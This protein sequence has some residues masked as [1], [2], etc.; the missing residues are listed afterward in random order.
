MEGGRKGLRNGA[1][2]KR[3]RSENPPKKQESKEKGKN[4]LSKEKGKMWG[5]MS[6]KRGGR[7]MYR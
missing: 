2:R 1:E 5:K 7:R 4:R 6:R 3:G